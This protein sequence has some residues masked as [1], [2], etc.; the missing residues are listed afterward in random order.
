ML[1]DKGYPWKKA[2]E[3]E[4]AGKRGQRGWR[5]PQPDAPASTCGTVERSVEAEE[6][7]SSIHADLYPGVVGNHTLQGEAAHISPSS[8][9]DAATVCGSTG[10]RP[11]RSHPSSSATP[12]L[13][14]PIR[15][16][17]SSGTALNLL[18]GACKTGLPFCKRCPYLAQ[19]LLGPLCCLNGP[20]SVHNKVNTRR[21]SSLLAWSSAPR[22][23][24]GRA[25]PRWPIG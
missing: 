17:V 24:L 4:E 5:G 19:C 18:T 20:P 14:D 16:P 9:S 10:P 3:G 23:V 2:A 22:A 21:L 13:S 1:K 8:Q 12:S 6:G 11:P 25:P 7:R 15:S